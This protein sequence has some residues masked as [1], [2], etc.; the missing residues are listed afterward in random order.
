METVRMLLQ[1]IKERKHYELV[2]EDAIDRLAPKFKR[3]LEAYG[4]MYCPCQ[5]QRSMDT[6]CPCKY[7]RTQGACRCG[8][9]KK[10]EE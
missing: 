9:F 5:S 6:L 8:L 2:T 7:M 10:A 4:E 1:S 3:Q